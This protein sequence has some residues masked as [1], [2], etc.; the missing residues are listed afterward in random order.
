MVVSNAVSP[1]ILALDA[2][3]VEGL[4]AAELGVDG[5]EEL[6]APLPAGSTLEAG[7]L[8][9]TYRAVPAD[10]SHAVR[11][12]LAADEVDSLLVIFA[13]PAA[14]HGRAARGRVCWSWKP[15]WPN[16]SSR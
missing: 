4:T 10:Y 12:L 15:A 11:A 7:V 1:A 3:R 13:P 2:A 6:L 9:L 5:T 16:P 14:G 8:Q